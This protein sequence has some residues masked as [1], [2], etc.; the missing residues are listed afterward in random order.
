MD[1]SAGSIYGVSLSSTALCFVGCYSIS[2]KQSQRRYA[3]LFR[4]H[5]ACAQSHPAGIQC[6][7]CQFCWTRL[8]GAGGATDGE[9]AQRV[10]SLRQCFET[11]ATSLQQLSR[12]FLSQQH[13]E[14]A[15]LVWDKVRPD[16]ERMLRHFL[17]FTDCCCSWNLGSSSILYKRANAMFYC[18]FYYSY[19]WIF[20]NYS[21]TTRLLW[22]S[23]LLLQT[24]GA[25]CLAFLFTLHFLWSVSWARSCASKYLCLPYANPLSPSD[26]ASLIS[27]LSAMAG[28]I[29][30]AIATTNAVIAA[31]IVMEGLKVLQGHLEQ[32]KQVNFT[33]RT[34]NLSA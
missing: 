19:C 1:T 4:P 15:M 30:P 27:S 26:V 7:L 9:A 31:L 32:C 24:R 14:H 25:T 6:L 28:N 18:S 34:D 21:R 16:P 13:E 23:L 33:L 11:F 8:N 2:L 3:P 29:I 12:R 20:S 22:T 17:H 10:W 5:P